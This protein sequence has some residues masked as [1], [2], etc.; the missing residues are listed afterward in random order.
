MTRR[1]FIRNSAGAFALFSIV[2]R[3]VV[4]GSGATPPSET[5]TMLSI[6]AGGRAASDIRGLEKAGVRFLALCDVDARRSADMRKAHAGV[7]FY[8]KYREMLDRHGKS[9]DAVSSVPARME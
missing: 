2:P 1:N 9:A 4:A 6:G 5:V 3:H 8:V 7:P